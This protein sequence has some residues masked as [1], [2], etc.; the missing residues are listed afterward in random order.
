MARSFQNGGYYVPARPVVIR[1]QYAFWRVA[2]GRW[3]FDAVRT[4]HTGSFAQ[5][6]LFRRYI[7]AQLF[8]KGPH[9]AASLNGWAPPLNKL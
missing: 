7:T 3:Y 8:Q 6:I 4:A 5:D 1:H 2:R 9:F